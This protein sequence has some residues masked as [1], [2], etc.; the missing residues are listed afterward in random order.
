MPIIRIQC[1]KE[2]FIPF[3]KINADWKKDKRYP[4]Q[5]IQRFITL[6]REVF[7][8]LGVSASIDE[9]NY[10]KGLRLITSNFIGA[11]PLRTPS[12]GKYYTDIHITSRF[13]ENISELAYLLKDT[14]EPE[15]IDKGLY[16]SDQ[17]RAPFYFD[18]INYFNSYSKALHDPWNKFDSKIRI[19]S[20][21]CSSTDWLKYIQKS[22]NPSN[23]FKFENRKN[24]LSREHKEWQ[25]LTYMLN[26][27]ICEFESFRTPSSIK[28]R[29]FSVV[30][31]LKK[32]ISGHQSVKPIAMFQIHTFDPPKIK[33]L[34]E[35]ANKL[36]AHNSTN[37]KT[38]RIDSAELF[39]RYVQYIL[40][41]VSDI[42]GA[43]IMC[44]NKISI[45]GKHRPSWVL[46]YLE[47]DIILHK[48]GKFYFADAKYKAHMLNVQSSAS[49]LK[50]T[51]RSDLH[52][53]LA[54]SSFDSS[55]NKTAILIY[56]CNKFKNIKLE[57]INKIGNVHNQIFLIGLPF[58]TV[59][60]DTFINQLS[61]ILRS[62]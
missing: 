3:A 26:I 12:S 53:I 48:D 21:P 39:E 18:C 41:Q 49:D 55:K 31:M 17:M 43:H 34:K 25:E 11:A 4:E 45:T 23:I 33:E 32:Y 36:L 8:F 2:H 50:E 57:A 60:L 20:N 52:Q 27:A 40:K 6:N 35:N 61:E 29:Y 42:N 14:L 46:R 9:V 62:N 59:G 47:P 13:G 16:H 19:E 24:I 30:A 51:F 10:E 58:T 28:H 15:Y 7:S 56:P 22:V 5:A 38:W 54:Y 44:N 1:L 37:S